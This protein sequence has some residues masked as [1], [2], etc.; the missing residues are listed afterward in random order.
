MFNRSRRNLAY[1]F[2]LSMGSIL[3]LFAGVVYY[4]EVHAQFQAF[5]ESFYKRSKEIAVIVVQYRLYHRRW[6]GDLVNV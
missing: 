3:I 5:D 4:R 6:W 2:V 1:W